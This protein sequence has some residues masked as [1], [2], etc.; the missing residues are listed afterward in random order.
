MAQQSSE[1]TEK[2]EKREPAGVEVRT[3]CFLDAM[4]PQFASFM[5]TVAR[6]Y[7]P[8]AGQATLFLE[9][10]PGLEINRLLDVALK[11]TD[12]APG[13]LVVEREFGV[14]EVHA[15]DQG[16]IR[17][18]GEAVLAAC[19]LA[20]SGCRP[21]RIVSSTIIRKVA[22]YQTM[23]INRMRHGQMLLGGQT[24]YI[25]ETEPAGY[26]AL[27]ANEAEKASHVNLLEV[28]TI[29]RFGRLYLGG[30]EADVVVAAEAAERSLQTLATQMKG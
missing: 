30:E 22:D 6:G 1:K 20:K 8:V 4:Q 28:L 2:T 10:A 26:A 11:A 18:A 17:R 9:I 15:E 23:L 14:F 24:L 29:G 25:L 27:A 13:M 16:S 19:G 12:V 7:L 3:Y 5:A 21:P